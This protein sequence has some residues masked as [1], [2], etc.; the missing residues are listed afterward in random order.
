VSNGT[1]DSAARRATRRD[2]E[3]VS[4]EELESAAEILD[5]A[6][7]VFDFSEVILHSHLDRDFVDRVLS[8]LHEKGRL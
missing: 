5:R 4:Q 2:L 7:F 3:D 1:D 8:R 6:K